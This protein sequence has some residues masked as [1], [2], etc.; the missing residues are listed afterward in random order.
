[1]RQASRP[2]ARWCERKA[3]RVPAPTATTAEASA[4][5]ASCRL[6][7]GATFCHGAAS[8]AR[9]RMTRRGKRP[10]RAIRLRFRE[11]LGVPVDP[12]NRDTLVD[13]DKGQQGRGPISNSPSFQQPWPTQPAERPNGPAEGSIMPAGWPGAANSPSGPA[14]YAVKL[15]LLGGGSPPRRSRHRRPSSVRPPSRDLASRRLFRLFRLALARGSA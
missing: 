2:E 3:A 5:V 11:S 13:D 7:S 14:S 9:R 1:M 8:A 10:P 4:V 15:F 12:A 6:A